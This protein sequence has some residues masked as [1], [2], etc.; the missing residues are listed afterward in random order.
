MLQIKQEQRTRPEDQNRKPDMSDQNIF[1]C[2]K[3]DLQKTGAFGA[4]LHIQ[5]EGRQ[6]ALDIVIIDMTYNPAN[7]QSDPCSHNH[8][9]AFV[10]ACPHLGMPLQTFDHQFLDQ[11]N[12]SIL[13]CSTH[14]A[15][16]QAQDGFC[17]SGPCK[18]SSLTPI[19][20]TFTEQSIFIKISDSKLS[21]H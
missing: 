21:K 20:L 6:N 7:P 17:L 19:S 1:L 14:G 18:G 3:S 16:F 12:P 11:T 10:N 4:S 2:H 15:R 5:K 9:K 8:Y 13:I